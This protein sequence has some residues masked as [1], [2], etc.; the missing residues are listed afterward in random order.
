MARIAGMGCARSRFVRP[1]VRPDEP[2]GSRRLRSVGFTLS[3]VKPCVRPEAR[4]DSESRMKT[5]AFLRE[6]RA[7]C[8][9]KDRRIDDV[10]LVA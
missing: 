8:G 4:E 7:L 10:Y 3:V 2:R 9:E 6:L 1:L 5:D